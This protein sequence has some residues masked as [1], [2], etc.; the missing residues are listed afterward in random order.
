M[1]N[2]NHPIDWPCPICHLNNPTPIERRVMEKIGL[3][4]TAPVIT[5]ISK[6][7]VVRSEDFTEYAHQIGIWQALCDIAGIDPL[8]DSDIE[9]TV[10]S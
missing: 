4:K 2:C 10:V 9:V 7:V 8:S 6:G 5:H 3:K 1:K